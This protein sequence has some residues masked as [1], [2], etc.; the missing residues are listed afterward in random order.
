MKLGRCC[1]CD[2]VA[3][4]C[5]NCIVNYTKMRCSCW[6]RSRVATC[7][8]RV[9]RGCS[10]QCP[11][12]A[13]DLVSEGCEMMG[14]GRCHKPP[15]S[16]CVTQQISGKLTRS[17]KKAK[18]IPLSNLFIILPLSV[19]IFTCSSWQQTALDR[20]RRVPTVRSDGCWLV[21]GVQDQRRFCLVCSSGK[22]LTFLCG[23]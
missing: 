10:R 15:A 13:Q 19:T 22:L 7:S 12:R 4:G 2:G 5:L 9:P 21:A 11:H 18:Y 23:H 1:K 6:C 20:D 14:D 16:T 8:S 3:A 17:R